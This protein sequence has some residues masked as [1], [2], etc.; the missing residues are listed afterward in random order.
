ML[1]IRPFQWSD[2][3]ALYKRNIQ[4]EVLDELITAPP[5]TLEGT[6][7]YFS[8]RLGNND[9]V[10]VAEE[11]GNVAGS[12]EIKMRRGKEAHVG[13]VSLAVKSE[14]WGHGVGTRLVREAIK[15]AKRRGLEKL[16]YNV[17]S[18]NKR[19]INLTKDLKFRFAARLKKNVKIGKKY[20]DMLFFEKFL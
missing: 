9:V 20:Y 19:S 4:P 3:E 14:F 17:S 1:K 8:Q 5:D 2:A 6:V 15:E 10:L 13:T 16:V 11:D 18:H 12:V 7:N